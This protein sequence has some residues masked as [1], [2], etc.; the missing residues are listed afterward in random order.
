MNLNILTDEKKNKYYNLA[1]Y[2]GE[3]FSKD[4][5][6]KVGG[7]LLYPDTLQIISTGYNGFPRGINESSE[8]WGRPQKYNY[9]VHAEMNMIYNSAKNG[10]CTNGSI[11]V[12]TLFP[13]NNCA[14]ALVQSGISTILT[15]KPDF[16]HERWGESFTISYNILTEANIN[17]IYI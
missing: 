6:T 15:S 11:A 8:R 17:I 14:L 4:P 10:S 3:N 9:V 5:N 12:I 2:I 16:N 13:C 7:L 1:I